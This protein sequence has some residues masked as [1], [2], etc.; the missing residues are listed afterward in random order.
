MHRSDGRGAPVRRLQ[1]VRHGLQS[2]RPRLPPAISAS[3]IHCG[4]SRVMTR[5]SF[6]AQA[7]AA[8]AVAQNRP[9][10]VL[11]MIADDLGLHTG[12]YGDKTA[13][14]IGRA[15]CRDGE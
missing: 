1:H 2:R 13:I 3:E 14:K 8:P 9:R 6:L 11:L 7:T 10:N 4:E 5:R 12:A 15:S